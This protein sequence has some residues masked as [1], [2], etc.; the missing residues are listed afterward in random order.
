VSAPHHLSSPPGF[1]LPELRDVTEGVGA[2]VLEPVTLESTYHDTPDLRLARGGVILRHRSDDGWVVRFEP[3]E[4]PS[5][6]PGTTQTAR[7]EHRFDGDPASP[8]DA[9]LELLRALVRT[10]KVAPVAKL[11]TR[12]R[13]TELHDELGK[14]LGTVT[15]DEVSVLKG[16]RVAARFRE[17]EVDVYDGAPDALADAVAGRL[18][19]AGAG[20]PDPTPKVVRALG[21][22]ALEPPDVSGIARLGPSPSA[23]DVVRAALA[24]SVAQ[25]IERDPGVRLGED[26]EDVHQAR[27][28]TRR[29]RSNLRTFRAILDREWTKPLRDR[30]R[31]FGQDLGA[32]RDT[33]VLSDRLRDRVDHL[34]AEDRD[35]AKR[36]LNRL[37]ERWDTARHALQDT[38]RS[39]EYTRLLDDVVDGARDPA[40][41]PEADGPATEVLPPLVGRL[42][43]HVK[44]AVE[45]LDDDPP[46]E[47]LHEVRKRARHC[48]YAA[49]SMT[50]VIGKP[51]K[52]FARAMKDLQDVLGE[53]QDAV[54]AERWLREVASESDGAETFVAGQLASLERAEIE[55]TRAAWPEAW[56]KASRKRL[57][58]WF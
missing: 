54:V 6:A 15:D 45:E 36:M 28:A 2:E 18:R 56:R 10:E 49:E 4:A 34:S 30:L 5:S 14:T 35:V 22:S 42:W 23:G 16:R 20:P 55:R 44:K 29:L 33:E 25:L 53:H 40:L 9:A 26:P 47:A 8:P 51:A 31:S 46:D 27:V 38:L 50:P 43:K 37:H 7:G 19:T 57:R 17:L 11:R 1:R 12:R 3:H 32:V 24:A 13:R 41:L 21:W 48:R 52:A 39:A 58:Q